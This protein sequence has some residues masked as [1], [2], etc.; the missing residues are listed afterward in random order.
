MTTRAKICYGW[1][2]DDRIWICE[3]TYLVNYDGYPEN[4]IPILKGNTEVDIAGKYEH[5]DNF[6]SF[7]GVDYI[8]YI[9]ARLN[10]NGM[11]ELLCTILEFD[12]K[13]YNSYGVD[14]YKVIEELIL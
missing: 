4:I 6:N 11:E 8:Y 3:D 10:K 7:D 9:E 5:L 13:F 14:N 2:R 12:W 1:T